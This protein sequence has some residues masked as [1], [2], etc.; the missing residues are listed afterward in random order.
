MRF[1]VEADADVTQ[2]RMKDLLKITEERCP[3]T[4]CVTRV[5][6]FEARLG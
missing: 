2:E 4:E 5:L 3:G 6:P 1:T